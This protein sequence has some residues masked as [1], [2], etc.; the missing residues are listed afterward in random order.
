MP[1]FSLRAPFEKFSGTVSDAAP[2]VKLVAYHTALYGNVS[3]RWVNPSQTTS[4]L[5]ENIWAITGAASAAWSLLNSATAAAWVALAEANP[6]YN[7]LGVRHT[8][9]GSALF[10]RCFSYHA[11]AGNAGSPSVP[12]ST[13]P[14]KK[15]G[16][17]GCVCLSTSSIRFY[18]VGDNSYY[19]HVLVRFTRPLPS[20]VA[21][22]RKSDCHCQDPTGSFIDYFL[23]PFSTYFTNDLNVPDSVYSDADNIGVLFQPLTSDWL[24]GPPTFHPTKIIG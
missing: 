18:C 24:P 8:L 17:V 14:T 21:R 6:V 7:R 5:R 16:I 19:S 4:P 12:T 1:I 15:V 23:E 9:S 22:A 20:P 10:V 2:G 13:W 3:R 11:M